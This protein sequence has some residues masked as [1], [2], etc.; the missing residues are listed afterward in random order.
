MAYDADLLV[1]GGGPGG[2]ATALQARR[3]GL[4]VI[5]AEPR[6]DPIDKACGEGLMPGGLAELTSL[7][8]DPA[9][10]PFRGIAYLSEQRRVQARFRTGPGRGVRRTT[11]H[12]ALAERA[13]EQ[14][15]EWIRRRVTGVAQDA[16]GVTAAGVRAKWL[17]AADGLHSAVRRAV[18]ITATAG[19]PRRYGVR[20]H[21]RV[22]VWSDFVEVH[23]SRWGEA[24]V[25]PV[26]SDLV[27]VAILSRQRPELDWFPRLAR[28]L[29]GASPGPA[30]G[31]G[32]LRQVVSRRVAGRVL[33][34]GDAA[35]YEDALTGE[36]ISLAVK[37]A[38]AAVG[39][40]VDDAPA[41]YEVA[42]HRITRDYRL[43][44]RGLVLASTPT[45]ARRAIVPACA[46][47]P[48]VFRWGVNVLAH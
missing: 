40:I 38:A 12:A 20:W 39:A 33:L 2:L 15:T 9:G 6:C 45:A 13:K 3:Q 8:V 10:M 4:S 11:L 1:V 35:G 46:L 29:K 14:D 34:V 25:T 28:H 18:G 31:C 36:G 23:W 21:F 42:W 17:V 43:L 24:Y 32:P 48:P 44:T 7:G 30:R 41:S 27:G 37:Q 16:H 26:E 19:T 47:L 22:P 5:V